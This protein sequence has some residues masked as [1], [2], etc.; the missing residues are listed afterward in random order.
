MVKKIITIGIIIALPVLF[1]CTSMTQREALLAKNW[2]RSYETAR[3]TQIMNPDAGEIM[4]EEQGLDGIVVG[5]NYDKY[6]KDFQKEQDT[7]KVFNI[8]LEDTQE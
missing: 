5:H 3:F 7:T 8:N 2:G 4:T 1:G 6:Q